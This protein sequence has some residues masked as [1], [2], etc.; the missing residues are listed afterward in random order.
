MTD[1]DAAFPTRSGPFGAAR[2]WWGGHPWTQA[3]VIAAVILLFWW[4][5]VNIAASMAQAGLSPGFAFLNRAANFEIGEN[6]VGYR[7]G[8]AYGRALAAGFLNTLKAA[9]LGC[10]LATALGVALA[11][12]RLS[13]NPLL[14]NLVRIFIELVRNTPLLL[15]LFF[16]AALARALPPPRQATEL[17]GAVYLT[18]RGVFIPAVSVEGPTGGSA[19]IAAAVV[20]CVVAAVIAAIVAVRRRGG[21]PGRT[22]AVAVGGGL[23]LWATAA[24]LGIGAHVETPLRG[25]FNI[26]GGWSL[27]PEFAVLL[28]GLTV[29]FSAMIAEIVRSGV[30]SVSKGQWEAARALGLPERRILR[31]VVAPQALRVIVPMLTSAYLDLT[32]DSSLAVAIGYPDLVSIANTTANTTGQATEAL[33]IIV[34]V[35]LTLNLLTSAAMNIYNRRV[36][37]RGEDRR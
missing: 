12:A 27:T 19:L 5:G 33:S 34:V 24:A 8:D 29:K 31:L 32:K 35:Y 10:V 37:L 2:R 21:S 30:E 13:G 16:W 6:I 23:V 18:N 28:L 36:A 9:A 20:A 17:L 22:A 1:V 15:Q 3:T 26:Q 14:T 7:A 11:T 4:F 25:G